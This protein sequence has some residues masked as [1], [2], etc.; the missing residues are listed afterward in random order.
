MLL[1]HVRRP[2]PQPPHEVSQPQD[3]D[4]AATYEAAR[5]QLS[6]AL[7]EW[8]DDIAAGEL[9]TQAARVLA[10][11]RSEV[12]EHGLRFFGPLRRFVRHEIDVW[13]EPRLLESGQIS[14]D[15]IVASI[16]LAA[17]DDADGAPSAR[18]FYTW[19]R[20]IAR[21]EVR[22]AV[23]EQHSIHRQERSLESPVHV[24]IA[25][26]WPDHVLRLASVL[27]NPDAERPEDLLEQREARRAFN[28]VLARLPERWREVFLLHVID[29]WDDGA[30]A[31]AEGIELPEVRNIIESTLAF[32]RDWL[33]E[34]GLRAEG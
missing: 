11:R 23:V 8:S 19:L 15:D 20:R 2:Q 29:G 13:A 5:R 7:A 25:G 1:A 6:R 31:E 33:G 21:R 30:I 28:V 18:A 26:D 22:A 32:L 12:I 14:V 16:Y 4:T 34:T 17:V 9:D 3:Q 24:T 10:H 27:A